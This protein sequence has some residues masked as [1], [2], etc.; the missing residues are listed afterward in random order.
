MTENIAEQP[1]FKP[2]LKDKQTLL[3]IRYAAIFT[4]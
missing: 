2:P 1:R 4:Q 3:T